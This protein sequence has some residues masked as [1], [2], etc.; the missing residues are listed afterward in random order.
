[1][2]HE[3]E[4]SLLDDLQPN[5]WALDCVIFMHGLMGQTMGRWDFLC[6]KFGT[7]PLSQWAMLLEKNQK[8]FSRPWGW[9]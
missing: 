4:Q 1:M 9:C 7:I 6:F 3:R 2:H 8:S 5:A